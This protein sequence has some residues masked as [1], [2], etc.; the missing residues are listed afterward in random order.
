MILPANVVWLAFKFA[1][2]R[3]ANAWD[4]DVA[5]VPP[6]AIATAPAVRFEPL[7]LVRFEPLK[8]GA[9]CHAGTA[10]TEPV[11]VCV[12]TAVCAAVLPG[13]LPGEPLLFAATR[14]PTVVVNGLLLEGVPPLLDGVVEDAA[15]FSKNAV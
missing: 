1:P 12:N 6:F 2:P 11:P 3:F 7:R 8:A 9:V 5:P 14:S 15:P 4:A 13:S 10:D